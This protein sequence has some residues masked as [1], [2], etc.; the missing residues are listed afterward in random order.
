MIE[1]DYKI[2]QDNGIDI[3]IFE[4]NEILKRLPDKVNIRGPNSKG[5]STLLHIIGA[6][7][8][9]IDNEKIPLSLQ[10]KMRHIMSPKCQLTFKIKILND[11]LTLISE[12]LDHNKSDFNVYEISNGESKELSIGQFR[13]K[14][15][16]IYNIPENPIGRFKEFPREIEDS[17][18]MYYNRLKILHD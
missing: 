12:K 13:S 4:P 9:G 8:Y 5:K 7:F 10:E 16:V 14:Y 1:S 15:N 3:D 17:Q 2:V 18:R 6:G 11:T